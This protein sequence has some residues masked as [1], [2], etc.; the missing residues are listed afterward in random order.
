VLVGGLFLAWGSEQQ[1]R[2]AEL[3]ARW[4][5]RTGWS[6]VRAT[7]PASLV[8]A[9]GLCT[10]V[11]VVEVVATAARMHAVTQPNQRVRVPAADNQPINGAAK[12]VMHSSFR[13]TL[14]RPARATWPERTCGPPPC[15][16][17]PTGRPVPQL[18]GE[19]GRWGTGVSKG[20]SSATVCSV[21]EA[22][23]PFASRP[24]QCFCRHPPTHAVRP[25]HTAHLKHPLLLSLQVRFVVPRQAQDPAAGLAEHTPGVTD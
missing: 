5:E 2:T 19:L 20:G 12:T 14:C 17:R 6:P 11:M 1:R 22:P 15:F 7:P 18:D 21:I 3:P 10:C 25:R 9:A 4:D 13:P 8:A 23:R 24:L 16:G